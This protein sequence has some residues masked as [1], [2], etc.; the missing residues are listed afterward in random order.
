MCNTVDHALV[1]RGEVKRFVQEAR[2][3]YDR[4]APDYSHGP[5]CTG[6]ISLRHRGR[7][8][9]LLDE[10]ADRGRLGLGVRRLSRAGLGQ[11]A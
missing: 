8:S 5:D 10:A 7:L 6:I 2:A 3:W 9:E 11:G 1:P 4:A